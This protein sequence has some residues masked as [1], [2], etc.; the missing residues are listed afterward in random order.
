MVIFLM[1][2]G[3]YL[4]FPTIDLNFLNKIEFILPYIFILII[5]SNYY[6]SYKISCKIYFKKEL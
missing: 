6:I 2:G 5:I 1:I 4:L 3:L